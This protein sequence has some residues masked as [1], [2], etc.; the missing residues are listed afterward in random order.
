MAKHHVDGAAGD[1]MPHCRLVLLRNAVHTPDG[2]KFHHRVW[3]DVHQNHMPG[4]G[5]SETGRPRARKRAACLYHQNAAV[6][7]VLEFGNALSLYFARKGRDRHHR[8]FVAELVLKDTLE[9]RHRP[10]KGGE[11]DCLL[12][13]ELPRQ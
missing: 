13:I 9:L 10:G 4:S 6:R 8:A 3:Q 11:D 12:A 2:L 5:Q 7:V 1:H